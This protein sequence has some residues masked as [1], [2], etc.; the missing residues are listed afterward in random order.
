[1]KAGILIVEDEAVVA[2]DLAG[3]LTRVGYR[4][5][6]IAAKGEQAIEKALNAHPDLVLM[7]IRLPGRLDGIETA[8]QIL[9][10]CNVPVVYLTAHS[11]SHTL[12]RAQ[13]TE[14]FGYILKPFEER[15]L[16]TQ[17]EIALYK[18]QAERRLRESEMRYRTLVEGALDTILTLDRN[19]VLLSCNAAAER[20]FRYVRH[21]MVGENVRML[22]PAARS[23]GSDVRRMIGVWRELEGRRKDGSVF[24]VEVGVSKT[25]LEGETA[26]TA[27]LRDVTE[28]KRAEE[29]IRWRASL[30]EQT[31]EAVIV[32][33]MGDGIVYWN[34]GACELYGWTAEE[35]VGRSPH[36]LLQSALPVSVGEFDHRL[37]EAGRWYGKIHQ[38]TKDGRAVVVESRMVSMSAGAAAT[39]VMETNRDVTERHAAHEQLC[40]LAEELE[41]R[42]KERTRDLVR[43]QEL[44][45]QL[46]SE[47]T[48][49][50]QRERRKL[51]T[52]LHDYLAQLLVCIRL[53]VSQARARQSQPET[54]AWLREAEDVVQQSLNYTRSLVAQLAPVML[55]EFGLPVALT[56]LGEQ[57]QRQ[58]LAVSV[59]VG[60]AGSV[61]L[62]EDQAILLFQS[63]RELLMNVVKHAQVNAASVR[64][65]MEEGE[66]R[67]EVR[68]QGAGFDSAAAAGPSGTNALSSKFGLFSIRERM[69]ALGGRFELHSAPGKGTT[70]TL[71]LP[72]GGGAAGETLSVKRHASSVEESSGAGNAS[73]ITHHSSRIRVLLVDDHVM[74]RQGLRSLLES[75]ADVEVVGEAGDGAEALAMTDALRPDVIVM[76]INMPKMDGVEATSRIKTRQP[77]AIVIGLSMH[78]NGHYEEQMKKAGASGYLSKESVAEHLYRMILTCRQGGEGRR[79]G[80]EAA[81]S[82]VHGE[83]GAWASP[84]GRAV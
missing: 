15:D 48:I 77:S 42:V 26:F 35:A 66:L 33:R 83:A 74:V 1:M 31:H 16:T 37:L 8:K 39:L 67:V 58:D 14:P 18:H 68:D 24:P 32:W 20:M 78:N 44:L 62:P 19:G 49:A 47:L 12:E 84:P 6:G 43:S 17:I 60:E 21:E 2:A 55:H 5:V 50:E 3:K 71:T 54:E 53:K 79:D 46:A 36:D 56:W 61:P 70:A 81:V 25:V 23:D 28:R 30:L 4:V 64:L 69:H 82:P 80:A 65:L 7:D 51:A 9:A 27:I 52:D 76:D 75:H 41:H 63:V 13:K 38:R 45:R 59:D 22:L 57:M 34:R 72:L 11:D 40:R 29:E 73:R 10:T